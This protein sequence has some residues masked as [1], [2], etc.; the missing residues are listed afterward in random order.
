M[1]FQCPNCLSI[2]AIE[3][4][5]AGQAVACGHCNS[6]IAV[7]GSRLAPGAVIDD[8]VIEKEIGK[9]GLAT[10]YLAHQLSLDR[11]VALK[12]LHEEYAADG[13]FIAN[14]IREAR[15]AAQLNHPNIVQ[16]YAVGEEE[17]I[18]FFAMEYVQGTTLKSI[19]AHSG[20]LVVD[21]ALMIGREIAKAIDF[22]WKEKQLVHRDIKPDNII[23]MESGQVKLAD[24]GLARA[25]SDI[26]Q[27]GGSEILGTPQYIAPELLLGKQAD[28]RTDIYSLGATLYH[29]LT[30]EYPYSGNTATEIARKH[31]SDPLRSPHQVVADIPEPVSRLVEI[32]LAKRPG[33]RFDSA[34]E[35]IQELDRVQGGKVPEHTLTRS[36]QKPIDL[37]NVDSEL[38]VRPPTPEEAAAE[39]A[40]EK[41]AASGAKSVGGTTGRRLKISKKKRAGGKATRST[42]KKSK[43]AA[44]SRARPTG[45]QAE[46]P[47]ATE[48]EASPQET[49]Q[50][51]EATSQ[52][53]DQTHKEADTGE[54]AHVKRRKPSG[55][56]LSIG[57]MA[58]I[59]VA[60]VVVAIIGI[61]IFAQW[62]KGRERLNQLAEQG[63]TEKQA[64]LITQFS[65]FT[66]QNHPYE[67]VLERARELRASF[68]EAEAFKERIM[69]IAQPYLE[70]EIRR[71]R[72]QQ[73]RKE[74]DDWRKLSRDLQA[75][76]RERLAELER[77]RLLEEQRRQEQ[78]AAEQARREREEK[79]E[80][81]REQQSDLRRQAIQLCQQHEY[82]RAKT[83]FTGMTLSDEPEFSAWAKAKQDTIDLASK[84]FNLVRNSGDTL[85]GIK[86]SVPKHPRKTEIT[87]IG[88]RHIN[89]V[90]REKVYE[91]GVFVR[92]KVE[93]VTVPL[94]ECP[95]EQLMNLM[96]IAWRK[97]GGSE[98][99]F[100]LMAG[101]YLLA[102]G[103][104][105]GQSLRR[106]RNT[107]FTERAE[108]MI[109]ELET[110]RASAS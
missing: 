10:V 47:S 104:Q 27:E 95:S 5:Q 68:P 56:K 35:F 60:L 50:A 65:S 107:E 11:S 91:R 83:L 80:K 101:A 72:E 66:K 59:V 7:P 74:L 1:R 100:N 51:E 67:T 69:T 85:K 87:N 26:R 17:G 92:E 38:E 98:S 108:P 29:A 62:R 3:D 89:S 22:A 14:F 44:V 20:R 52:T 102:R 79:L 48:E 64:S 78:R 86:I 84:A 30:G 58:G 15:A 42:A 76:E 94:D 110:I 25:G 49:P 6:I 77:Q 96:E 40:A 88:V 9:G 70:E 105:L 24:L 97:Q 55:P 61:I 8:F 12:I 106:L 71:L 109:E 21:R 16:A 99:E 90:I 19:L 81:L 103:E 2:V 36:F 13:E 39:E 33:H 23:L 93:P 82:D 41:R 63:L 4:S 75:Q 45:T 54:N 37:G 28:N 53:K 43:V 32:M 57:T 34:E 73:Y 46:K 31:I 18:H